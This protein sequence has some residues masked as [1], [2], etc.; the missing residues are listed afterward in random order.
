MNKQQM[1]EIIR[2][3]RRYNAGLDLLNNPDYTFTRFQSGGSAF[4]VEKATET[5]TVIYLVSV[6]NVHCTCPDFEHNQQPCKHWFACHE[7][8]KQNAQ[9]E[10]SYDP[11]TDGGE[12]GE[13]TDPDYWLD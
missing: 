5:E 7:L 1:E 13:G 11:N 3:A 8:L 12:T 4:Y 10:E 2:T 6:D 9:I